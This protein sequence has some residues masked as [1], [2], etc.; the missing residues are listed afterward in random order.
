[1]H[2][3]SQMQ[4]LHSKPGHT[5]INEEQLWDQV[6]SVIQDVLTGL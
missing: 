3:A 2:F 6:V 5:E 1:M 4:L